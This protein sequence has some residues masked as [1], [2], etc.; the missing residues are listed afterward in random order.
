MIL[1]TPDGM[2]L[3]E[4]PTKIRHSGKYPP[5]GIAIKETTEMSTDWNNYH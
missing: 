2:L 1:G 3:K 4:M 5:P